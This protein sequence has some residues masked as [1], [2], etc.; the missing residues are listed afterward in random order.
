MNGIMREKGWY[1]VELSL[2]NPSMYELVIE[3]EKADERV[4]WGKEDFGD[5]HRFYRAWSQD[6]PDPDEPG[7]ILHN[8]RP[9][10]PS[11]SS[12]L[13]LMTSRGA[14]LADHPLQKDTLD[15]LI[16]RIGLEETEYR[17]LEMKTQFNKIFGVDIW[18]ASEESDY[19]K[20][21]I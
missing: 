9:G 1:N 12:D 7:K 18:P 14:L 20:L 15:E 4:V 2:S 8:M 5:T 11:D 10:R 13:D 6:D 16:F 17:R 19:F 21:F 3:L